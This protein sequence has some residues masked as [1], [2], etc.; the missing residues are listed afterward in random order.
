MMLCFTG[1]FGCSFI[2]PQEPVSVVQPQ[3]SVI[4]KGTVIHSSL[5]SAGGNLLVVP[6]SA[7][8][9]V[10]DTGELDRISLMIVKG[11]VSVLKD[12]GSPFKVLVADNADTA[13]MMIKGH[14]VR[15]ETPWGVEKWM[16]GKKKKIF[17]VKG[18]L[19][20]RE[21]GR[22]VL[23]FSH[24]R[25]TAQD[26]LSFEEMGLSVGEDVGRFILKEAKRGRGA[27]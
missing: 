2:R 4:V 18:K 25:H 23:L 15:M 5:L 6:F 16:P 19:I 10:A 24:H 8:V 1:I 20:E 13:D 14:V 3:P 9:G 26:D 7:G 17:G 12:R 21:K 27:P 22:T 11:I